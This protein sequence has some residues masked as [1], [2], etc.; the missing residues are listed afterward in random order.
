[1]IALTSFLPYVIDIN[2]YSTTLRFA[3][4]NEVAT[5]N[6]S[7]V[8]MSRIINCNR[9]PSALVTL[10]LLFL[11]T[12]TDEQLSIFR[13]AVGKFVQDRPRIWD[14]VLFFR[15]D[16]ISQNLDLMECTLRC[17]HTKSWQD[18]ASILMNKS[19][20]LT[21]CFEMG[22][23]LGVNYD[24]PPRRQYVVNTFEPSPDA[25][26]ALSDTT[27]VETRVQPPSYPFIPSDATKALLLQAKGKRR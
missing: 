6:N 12:T 13:E 25:S 26:T 5:V 23:T 11:D 9:S 22:K 18:A 24:S 7:S 1:L 3:A 8:A 15:K 20:L 27:P 17:R 14:S 21:F 10:D 4:T 2:L 19:E 16:A